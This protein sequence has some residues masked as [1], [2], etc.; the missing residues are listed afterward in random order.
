[1]F[2][3]LE[4][5]YF[6]ALGRYAVISSHTLLAEQIS[7]SVALSQNIPTWEGPTRI[8]KST[9]LWMAHMGI[10]STILVLWAPCSK[11]GSVYRSQG[12][13][14]VSLCT[15]ILIVLHLRSMSSYKERT[16]GFLLLWIAQSLCH[17]PGVALYFP[18]LLMKG[19]GKTCPKLFYVHFSFQ[20]YV[21]LKF[22]KKHLWW[23]SKVH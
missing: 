21:N 17:T 6:D 12:S 7:M 22:D 14:Q 16:T 3:F 5:G 1:M 20:I 2:V 10:E 18:H 23:S 4:Q 9:F 15:S 8:T 11:G 19:P 13:L